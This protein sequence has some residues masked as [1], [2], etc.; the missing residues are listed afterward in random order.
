MVQAAISKATDS[1]K[2]GVK[3]V[4]TLY[5]IGRNRVWIV[6]VPHLEVRR[7]QRGSCLRGALLRGVEGWWLHHW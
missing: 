4:Q 3:M 1:E 7:A 5:V 2:R 6:N